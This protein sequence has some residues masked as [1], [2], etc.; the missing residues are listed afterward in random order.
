M[1]KF[2]LCIFLAVLAIHSFA[3]TKSDI[4]FSTANDVNGTISIEKTIV[5]RNSFSLFLHINWVDEK[6]QNTGDLKSFIVIDEEKLKTQIP[7]NLEFLRNQS[8]LLSNKKI[9]LKFKVKSDYPGGVFQFKIPFQ[10]A[11]D[12]KAA[13]ENKFTKIIFKQ[14][15]ALLANV[16]IKASELEDIQPPKIKLLSP[17]SR[18]F[19]QKDT[20]ILVATKTVEIKGIVKDNRDVAKVN[21]NGLDL[22]P[23]KTGNFSKEIILRTGENIVEVRAFD[24]TGNQSQLNLRLLCSYQY[25][26]TVGDGKYFALLIA[27]ENYPDASIEN[28][29]NPIKDAEALQKVLIGK[30]TFDE[31]NVTIVK[32]P[33]RPELLEKFEELAEQVGENDNVLI[34][35]AGHGYWDKSK[36]I[37]YWLPTDASRSIKAN[38]LNNSTIKDYIH[39][40]NSKHTLLISDACF[41]GSIFNARSTTATVRAYKKLYNLPSRKGMTSGTLE[42]V[43]DKSVF[44]KYLLKRLENNTDT[45]LSSE[46]LF[47]QLRPAVL[48]NSPNVPQYGAIRD[49]GD[50]GGEFI[51]ILK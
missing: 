20:T 13:T 2:Y 32:N 36:S 14:P 39:A 6:L 16:A 10:Y 42:E 46:S 44:I 7:K 17:I 50:E 40:I 34:F 18:G 5:E 37:G 19:K 8:T 11:Q 33:T 38:W 41:S 29:M 24:K 49:T 26:I 27:A 45:Y 22:I 51:F 43:P 47:S 23:D 21:I 35:Y 3:D 4:L 12:W 9:E 1:K 28:L 48:N 31:K 15:K 25:D 30:Y